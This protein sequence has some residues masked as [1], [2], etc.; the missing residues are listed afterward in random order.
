M[1]LC[2]IYVH[3]IEEYARHN[4]HADLMRELL[5]APLAGEARAALTAA[6]VLTGASRQLGHVHLAFGMIW[7][8]RVP[9]NQ[10]DGVPYCAAPPNELPFDMLPNSQW[11]VSPAVVRVQCG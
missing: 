3:M 11:H 9:K 6:R 7:P 4:G 8:S 2:W 5:T 10:A 1:S